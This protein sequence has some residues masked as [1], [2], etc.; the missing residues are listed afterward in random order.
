MEPTVIDLRRY[1]YGELPEGLRQLLIDVHSDAYA[2]RSD[3]EFTQ[4]FPWFVDHWT[5]L[6]GFTCVVAYDADEPVGFAY[7]A[8]LATGQEWWREHVD[9]A[10]EPSATFGVSE[11]MVRPNWRKSGT[12]ER[13]HSQL[14]T[15]RPEDLAVLLVDPDHPKVQALYESWGYRPV[16]FRQPFADSPRYAVMLRSLR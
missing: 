15:D 9:P 4:R 7:G 14:I 8:P 11:L 2:D 16:G 13:L 5:S 10:P 12:S 6:P 3:D 1:Q